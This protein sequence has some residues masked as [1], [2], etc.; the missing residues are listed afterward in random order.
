MRVSERQRDWRWRLVEETVSSGRRLPAALSNDAVLRS[1]YA[2]W[3]AFQK[4]DS[5]TPV[6]A[7]MSLE[8][9]Y[10]MVVSAYSIY[11]GMSLERYFIEAL[12]MA[13]ED[14][15]SISEE[16]GYSES[17]IRTY[18]LLFFDVR[19]KLEQKLYVMGD[20][21]GPMFAHGT[22]GNDYDHLWKAVGYF[23]GADIL[24]AFWKLGRL[25]EDQ[26]QGLETI[27]RTRLL[28]QAATAT[29]ARKPTSFNSG[30]VIDSF[31]QYSNH[32][33]AK[34]R[35]DTNLPPRD[36]ENSLEQLRED[37]LNYM[38]LTLRSHDAHMGSVEKC[39]AGKDTGIHESEYDRPFE[40]VR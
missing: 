35:K 22:S 38:Q 8:A 27:L 32:E 29:F 15:R 21:L 26:R 11:S 39:L 40:L 31:I 34:D 7:L 33:V 1:A 18:E 4:Q 30:E 14:R 25:D 3:N 36:G 19:D 10:P 2:F 24:K 5:N 9:R 28:T 23:C 6:L 37:V 13:G 17:V 16:A 12:I 20:V